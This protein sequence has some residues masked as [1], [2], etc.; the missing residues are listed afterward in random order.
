MSPLRI[1]YTDHG[2]REM[3]KARV[4]RQ[5]IRSVLAYGAKEFDGRRG[6]EVYWLNTL[7]IGSKS[8]AVSWVQKAG[9]ALVITAYRVGEHD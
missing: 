8:Y 3:R 5:T 4:T 2:V 6:R 7:R 9:Y 1:H